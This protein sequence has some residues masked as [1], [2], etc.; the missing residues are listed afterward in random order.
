MR[1]GPSETKVFEQG[2]AH[3]IYTWKGVVS[4]EIL[5]NSSRKT[6]GPSAE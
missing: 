6:V 4:R 3:F 1:S 5:H 2:R